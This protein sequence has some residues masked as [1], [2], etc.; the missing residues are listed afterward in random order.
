ML[1]IKENYYIL[2]KNKLI[3]NGIYEKIKDNSIE[4]NRI[5][6]YYEIG[7]LLSEV[8]SKYGDNIIKI[9]ADKLMIEVGK[10]SC[11]FR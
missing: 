6:T 2:I 11:S 7:K 5:V 3:D 10:Y 8:E 1:N 9:Y 4:K